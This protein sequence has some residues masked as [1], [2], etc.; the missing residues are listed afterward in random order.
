MAAAGSRRAELG[1]QDKAIEWYETAHQ[2][3]HLDAH[4]D[5]ALLYGR[6]GMREESRRLMLE[7]ARDND[8]D[9]MSALGLLY[10]EDGEI[11]EARRWL[12][13]SAG[14]NNPKGLNNLGVLLR[15]QGEHKRA[16]ETFV[17]A[18]NFGEPN[19]AA[20]M[21]SYAIKRGNTLAAVK[22]LRPHW[23]S[24]ESLAVENIEWII[25]RQKAWADTNPAMMSDLGVIYLNLGHVDQAEM[26]LRK[27]STDGDTVAMRNLAIVLRQTQR[28]FEA[29]KWLRRAVDLGDSE[30]RTQLRA[31]EADLGDN[32]RE[33]S[34]EF[35]PW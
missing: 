2:A 24:G 29:L 33:L 10:L 17:R 18:A 15:D 27:A 34:E 21:S 35:R 4:H 22:W 25:E 6:I 9:A 1:E 5:L 8:D 20:S 16:E 32:G 12:E 11:E 3:G 14:M 7:L 13:R 23:A 26:C 19:A 31:L 30:A 28:A